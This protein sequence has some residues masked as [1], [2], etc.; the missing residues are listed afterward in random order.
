[1]MTRLLTI[2]IVLSSM[3]APNCE[4][5]AEEPPAAYH[6]ITLSSGL[7]GLLRAEMREIAEGVQRIALALATADWKTVQETSAMIH[8]SYVMA[9]KLTPDQAQELAQALPKHFKQ[10]D[11]DFHQRAAKLGTAA[12][13]HDAELAVFHYARLVESCAVCHSAYAQSR[14]PGFAPPP[15][16]Q[17]HHH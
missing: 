1:M 10:L 4:L 13:A 16:Q 14:F 5:F 9:K 8:Q 17:G 7:L 6:D 2:L 3:L 12:S 11:A 15:V